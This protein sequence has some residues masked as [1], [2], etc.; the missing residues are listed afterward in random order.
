MFKFILVHEKNSDLLFQSYFDLLI[1]NTKL[2]EIKMLCEVEYNLHTLLS[3]H[4]NWAKT[5]KKIAK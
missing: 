4:F 5:C 1:S 3:S 2:W